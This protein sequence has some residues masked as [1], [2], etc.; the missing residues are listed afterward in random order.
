M[1]QKE[2]GSLTGVRGLAALYVTLHHFYNFFYRYGNNTSVFHNKYFKSFFLH[3]Y[4]AVDVFF[5]LSAF[6]ITLSSSKLFESGLN[7]PNYKLFMQRRWVRVY[8]AYFFIIAFGYVTVFRFS[9]S[10]NFI[11]SLTLLNLLFNVPPFFGHLWS[12]SAEWITYLFYPLFFK[13]S[14]I[15]ASLIWDYIVIG[16]GT[17]VLFFTATIINK[18]FFAPNPI[19]LY[20]FYPSL[21]RCFADYFIGIGALHIFQK[22]RKEFLFSNPLALLFC[23]LI[24]ASLFFDQLDII[25]ILLAMF[26]IINISKDENWVAK[27]LSS[28]PVYFLGIIS[29]PLYLIHFLFY[30]KLDVIIT[31]LS[32]YFHTKSY[33]ILLI[34]FLLLSIVSSTLFTYLLEL[35]T[36]KWLNKVFSGKYN[37]QNYETL[38]LKESDLRKRKS[39]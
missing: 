18:N 7:F 2:I 16:T 38:I 21:I 17:L 5:V 25:T 35:P 23:A 31:F 22:N 32:S 20:Q 10:V 34:A 1:A 6:V 29:Y 19:Y 39:D 27:I 11:I 4:L 13:I 28:K 37:Y 15:R 33:Y 8:P 26:L 3:G 12:L 24:I 14:K 9:H 36:I 30:R